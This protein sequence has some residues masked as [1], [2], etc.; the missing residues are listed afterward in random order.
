MTLAGIGIALAA[1]T[2]AVPAHALSLPD[3]PAARVND[4]AKAL[5]PDAK[6]RLEQ[7][8]AGYE[9]GRTGQ[10][11][12]AIFRSLDGGAIED[13]SIRLA[14]KWKIGSKKNDDGVLLTVFL[15]D[16]KL[17][18]DSGYGVE[19]RLTDARSAQ[20]IRDLIAP[21]F[22]AG[23]IEQGLALGLAAIDTTITGRDHS[24]D[25]QALTAPQAAPVQSHSPSNGGFGMTWILLLLFVVL[26]LIR[27]VFG[28][29]RRSM[30]GGGGWSGG[31]RGWSIWPGV[32][33]GLL[34]GG[35][36]RG[37]RGGGGLFGGGG[38][39]GLFGGG[40]G[41]GFGGGGGSFGGGGASGSW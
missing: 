3:Q 34:G 5:S 8:L 29:R 26:P 30:L 22:K 16:H 20:I 1:V 24:H 31:S 21:R 33:G 25:A 19:D 17:R 2:A 37:G 41:G 40:G 9:K 10:I 12:V 32:A 36:L 11:A 28:R 39:G 18:I 27:L 7:Q 6:A 13:T 35:L 23:E 4:Y 38:G 14:E 15:E